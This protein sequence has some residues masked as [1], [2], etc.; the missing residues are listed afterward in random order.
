MEALSLEELRAADERTL[1]FTPYGLGGAMTPEVALDFQQHVVAQYTLAADVAEGTRQRFEQLR[2]VHAYGLL[3]YDLFTMV[4]DAALLVIEQALRDRFIDIHN[5]A[6]VIQ[7]SDGNEHQ[8]S[9]IGYANFHEQYRKLRG[10]KIQMGPT[11]TWTP[12]KGMLH[13][14]YTWAR[15]EGLLRGQRNR[16]REKA[17]KAL[18]NMVAHPNGYHLTTPVDAAHTLASLAEIINQL[19]GHQTPGGRLYPAPV[20]RSTVAI[21]W[22]AEGGRITICQAENLLTAEKSDEWEYV[23]VQAVFSPGEAEDPTLFEFDSLVENTTYPCDLL[24]GPGEQSQALAWLETN[25]PAAD[26]CDHL[27]RIFLIR[28]H[29]RLLHLPMRPQIAAGLPPTEHAGTWYT[30]RADDP[31]DAFSHARQLIQTAPQH[32]STGECGQ[33]SVATIKR[34]THAQ[35]LAAAAHEGVNV[36][37]IR[38]PDVRTPGRLPRSITLQP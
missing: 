27:D 24:W 20:D 14:L 29:D 36:A 2:R 17:I 19:W 31:R 25:Q 23:L 34:G 5:G 21:G 26:A 18:R 1:H 32:A 6:V 22:N 10:R 16:G 9:A 15:R 4:S 13:D 30:I 11:R 37:P 3:C 12:F 38:P 7:D 8:I 28:H 35:A 33:C